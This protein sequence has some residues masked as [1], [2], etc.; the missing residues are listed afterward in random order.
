[1]DKKAWLS[2]KGFTLVELLAV[3]VI[4]GIVAGIAIPSI[5][6]IIQ[7]TREDA[8]KAEALQVLDSAR[9]YDTTTEATSDRVI[10]SEE[11]SSYIEDV[12][13]GNYSVI[14]NSS[15]YSLTTS[16]VTAGNASIT[17]ECATLLE[18]NQD[19]ERGTRTI[20]SCEGTETDTETDT[21]TG[22]DTDN[23]TDGKS[24]WNG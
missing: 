15:N 14:V 19:S 8:V 18:I 6:G 13:L 5:G 24:F 16:T 1:M 23:G 12:D 21:D 2:Q 20:G 11:L 17:F 22:T 10:S 4:L 7:K 9:L 3:I